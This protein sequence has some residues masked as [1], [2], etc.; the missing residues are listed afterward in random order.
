MHGQRDRRR[1]EHDQGAGHEPRE[2]AAPAILGL[3]P[4]LQPLAQLRRPGDRVAVGVA[5]GAHHGPGERH[6][7][8][9]GERL[10][11]QLRVRRR[12][13]RRERQGP[14]VDGAGQLVPV[15]LVDDLQ[16]AVLGAAIEVQQAH[17]RDGHA[18]ADVLRVGVRRPRRAAG[19]ALVRALPQLLDQRVGGRRVGRQEAAVD[20]HHDRAVHVVAGVHGQVDVGLDAA[21]AQHQQK[22]RSRRTAER[23]PHAHRHAK[24]T[25]SLHGAEG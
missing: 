7:D 4:Q 6:P 15:V 2:R 16:A 5:V 18:A 23:A 22:R 9:D 10:R 11:D 24:A 1:R 8:D 21:R 20:G 17:V 12:V 13:V 3:G 19:R 25:L 14:G